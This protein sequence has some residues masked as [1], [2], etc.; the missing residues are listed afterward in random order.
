MNERV[1]R[2]GI[3]FGRRI[4]LWNIHEPKCSSIGK[5]ME[6]GEDIAVFP[7]KRNETDYISKWCCSLQTFLGIWYPGAVYQGVI[8]YYSSGNEESVDVH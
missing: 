4:W 5:N 7:K 8:F 6:F 2:Y 1:R 3:N